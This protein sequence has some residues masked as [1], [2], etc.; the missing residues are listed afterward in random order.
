MPNSINKQ[1]PTFTDRYKEFSGRQ[2]SADRAQLL[3]K[4]E[5]DLVDEKIVSSGKQETR[6]NLLKEAY[7][8]SL[9]AGG[10]LIS[11]DIDKKNRANDEE[12]GRTP[13]EWNKPDLDI[14][15]AANQAQFAQLSHFA[16]SFTGGRFAN[17]WVDRALTI[18]SPA[19]AKNKLDKVREG[20]GLNFPE[21]YADLGSEIF[22]KISSDNSDTPEGEKLENAIKEVITESYNHIK[23]KRLSGLLVT[24]SKATRLLNLFQILTGSQ[25]TELVLGR[26][27]QV[28]KSFNISLGRIVAVEQ[29]DAE[30]G[31]KFAD[32]L[33]ARIDK[34]TGFT[35]D[36]S[37]GAGL[38]APLQAVKM[39]ISG[40]MAGVDTLLTQ[41][42]GGT[43]A[44]E[45][46]K[47]LSEIQAKVADNEI[48]EAEA[49]VLI[50]ARIRTSAAKQIEQE[51][52]TGGKWFLNQGAE[53][54]N[55]FLGARLLESRRGGVGADSSIEVVYDHIVKQMEDIKNADLNLNG[56]EKTLA[57]Q[58]R[59][60]LIKE[61]KSNWQ[62]TAVMNSE[63]QANSMKL[64]WEKAGEI[65]KAYAIGILS[66]EATQAAME[67]GFKSVEAAHSVH[68]GNDEQKSLTS[69]DLIPNILSW[70]KNRFSSE[71]IIA[72]NQSNLFKQLSDA[73]DGVMALKN[74]VITTLDA[75]G[76]ELTGKK[77]TRGEISVDGQKLSVEINAQHTDDTGLNFNGIN[78]KGLSAEQLAQPEVKSQILSLMKAQSA[79]IIEPKAKILNH[80]RSGLKIIAGLESTHD[81]SLTSANAYKFTIGNQTIGAGDSGKTFV[82]GGELLTVLGSAIGANGQP[83]LVMI[84]V[85]K[86]LSSSAGSIDTSKIQFVQ[87]SKDASKGGAVGSAGPKS[88]AVAESKPTA[89][90]QVAALTKVVAEPIPIEPVAVTRVPEPVALADPAVKSAPQ[91]AAIPEH[92]AAAP[93]ET[94]TVTAVNPTTTPKVVESARAKGETQDFSVLTDTKIV[95]T[96]KPPSGSALDLKNLESLQSKVS[97]D[98]LKTG[99]KP[100]DSSSSAEPKVTAKPADSEF[101]SNTKISGNFNPKPNT[102]IDL[103]K[104]FTIGIGS[105]KNDILS[106]SKNITPLESKMRSTQTT[107]PTLSTD[108]SNRISSVTEKTF[109]PFD[110]NNLL[111]NTQSP[112]L[113]PAE[114]LKI[115]TDIATSTKIISDGVTQLNALKIQAEA[116]DARKDLSP[117]LKDQQIARLANQWD[118]LDAKLR[119]EQAAINANQGK[120]QPLSKL[121]TTTMPSS[122]NADMSMRNVTATT[123]AIPAIPKVF[124]GRGIDVT[125]SASLA[126]AIASPHGGIAGIIDIVGQEA[127]TKRLDQ[128]I[129]ENSG[130]PK[131]V[132]D[133]AKTGKLDP[134][135]ANI[136]VGGGTL[137]QWQELMSA[138]PKMREQFANAAT[139]IH[140]TTFKTEAEN[141]VKISPFGTLIG[142]LTG[143]IAISVEGKEA[144]S[145][146]L[147]TDATVSFDTSSKFNPT[148]FSLKTDIKPGETMSASTIKGVPVAFTLEQSGKAT[149][150][151]ISIANN[152]APFAT[153]TINDPELLAKLTSGEFTGQAAINAIEASSKT[154]LTFATGNS[155]SIAPGKLTAVLAGNITAN[156]KFLSGLSASDLNTRNVDPK[157]Q[158]SVKAPDGREIDVLKTLAN[159]S[160]YTANLSGV[161]QNNTLVDSRDF[162]SLGSFIQFAQVN[163]TAATQILAKIIQY[164]KDPIVLLT[165]PSPETKYIASVSGALNSLDKEIPG[166]YSQISNGVLTSATAAQIIRQIGNIDGLKTLQSQD[167]KQISQRLELYRDIE[168]SMVVRPNIPPNLSEIQQKILRLKA[169]QDYISKNHITF[170]AEQQ[171]AASLTGDLALIMGLKPDVITQSDKGGRAEFSYR[172]GN[173]TVEKARMSQDAVQKIIEQKTTQ[174]GRLYGIP[175]GSLDGAKT[176]KL[177]FAIGNILSPLGFFSTG[178][179]VREGNSGAVDL[180][181][182]M[183][184]RQLQTGLITATAL[185]EQATGTTIKKLMIDGGP[186]GYGLTA[187]EAYQAIAQ[188]ISSTAKSKIVNGTT[189]YTYTTPGGQV[190]ESTHQIKPEEFAAIAQSII[191]DA[192]PKPG[193]EKIGTRTGMT[194]YELNDLVIQASNATIDNITT[195]DKIVAALSV[196]MTDKAKI[197]VEKDLKAIG[198]GLNKMNQQPKIS[199]EKFN[200]LLADSTVIKSDADLGLKPGQSAILGGLFNKPGV[201]VVGD[202]NVGGK[203]SFGGGFIFSSPQERA[204]YERGEVA[205]ILFVNCHGNGGLAQ[206]SSVKIV[207][208]QKLNYEIDNTNSR[209]EVKFK[210]GAGFNKL[211][212]WF[213]GLSITL[214]KPGTPEQPKQPE[215][216]KTPDQPQPP[217]K[218]ELTPDQNPTYAAP[219]NQPPLG[220]NTNL[221]PS[222]GLPTNT[223]INGV[224]LGAT[225]P[226]IAGPNPVGNQFGF[227]GNTPP[228]TTPPVAPPAFTVPSPTGVVFNPNNVGLPTTI[229]AVTAPTAVV[230]APTGALF[231]PTN[232]LPNVA[233]ISTGAT[234]STGLGGFVPANSVVNTGGFNFLPNIG[235]ATAGQIPAETIFPGL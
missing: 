24:D 154:S 46:T 25:N 121:G 99:S 124:G 115:S 15:S 156:P 82:M 8:M 120:L 41:A 67:V 91:Q 211:R 79:S 11:R 183:D 224:T 217:K 54:I 1:T 19:W 107:L 36:S 182:V 65:S 55:F 2:I 61:A 92:V 231:N 23:S 197:A 48:T 216:P 207:I 138:D 135:R 29:K 117:D 175:I 34:D 12:A 226:P 17:S 45:T 21:L 228:M 118:A 139:Q 101:A 18:K 76:I 202:E 234:V 40:V 72:R 114:Q 158:I 128:M 39:L 44:S 96:I 51:K 155:E 165:N 145:G 66:A 86:A 179:T 102:K 89:P 146:V 180:Q 227:G 176:A 168:N 203:S 173:I 105:T 30:Y 218:I 80:P 149:S 213:T 103:D 88:D 191:I 212:R 188:Q 70:G 69:D 199:L 137:A 177:V 204:K 164:R 122:I 233:P 170:T 38:R 6:R 26:Q 190:I 109:K 126:Q 134:A 68:F 31:T 167:L 232:V 112:Q 71:S 50:E 4:E 33:A 178:Q 57:K 153:V 35:V 148:E 75:K 32:S 125:S 159:T 219:S 85:D 127:F 93:K 215:K 7:T 104:P 90:Q 194:P 209:G 221:T 184:T 169:V 152:G 161:K 198:E 174:K 147:T 22:E 123:P 37:R 172:S 3:Y 229:P 64:T 62:N 14:N 5:Q 98:S 94:A 222:N 74:T 10:T 185:G 186:N 111:K 116:L 201:T 81:D 53:A 16:A 142:L 13:K 95:G 220:Q 196:E 58:E 56:E 206:K 192:K 9:D 133:L 113:A 193:A 223:S 210:I 140:A 150:A 106:T 63:L 129:A 131:E 136:K 187:F 162:N 160:Q 157:A 171:A 108:Q 20:L 205:Q 230:G 119:K 100:L 141:T 59:Q 49:D 27:D 42:V 47:I 235:P 195:P 143:K 97:S 77:E 73:A 28:E 83:V 208:D 163:P 189:I 130:L 132:I 60:K 151:Q 166:L 181:S 87:Y 200:I 110:P 78:I 84:P 214:P 144:F 52:L 225:P 43:M